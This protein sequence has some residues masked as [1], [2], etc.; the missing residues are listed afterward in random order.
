MKTRIQSHRT[1]R[2][3]RLIKGPVVLRLMLVFIWTSI[4]GLTASGDESRQETGR[5]EP[6]ATKLAAYKVLVFSKT[7][8]YR[9]S[10]IPF[11]ITAIRHLGQANSFA[12]DATESATLFTDANLAQYRVVVFLNTT[13]DVLDNTQQ[14]AFQQFIRAGGGYVGIHSAADT[15]YGWAWYGALLGAYFKSHPAVQWGTIRIENRVHPSTVGLPPYWPR[16]D[17][18]YDFN[19]NPCGNVTVLATLDESTYSGGTMGLDHPIAWCHDY[20]GGRAWYTGVGHTDESFAEPL[21][22]A[23]ILG[24]IQWTAGNTV[25]LASRWTCYK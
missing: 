13:G 25:T 5:K 17:E 7:A 9:H 15:E 14:Q 6:Q 18:W 3:N 22:L 16:V 11:G 1:G 2:W 20:A 24:G 8:G 23:H 21:F 10:S 12:V 19:R 4:A